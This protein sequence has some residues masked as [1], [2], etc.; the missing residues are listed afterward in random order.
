[1]N[2]IYPIID[3]KHEIAN[4]TAG[5]T[6]EAHFFTRLRWRGTRIITGGF[7]NDSSNFGPNSDDF[8][9]STFQIGI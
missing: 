2:E 7:G 5:N 8:G 9:S 4:T 1:M 6:S 3:S